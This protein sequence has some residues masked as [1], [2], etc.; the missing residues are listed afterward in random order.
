MSTS[1]SVAP[2]SPR[3]VMP[4]LG[5]TRVQVR[6]DGAM[7]EVEPPADLAVGESLGGEL[8]DLELLRREVVA[9]LR[10]PAPAP[11]AGRAQL[12][13]RLLA[14]GRATPWRSGSAQGRVRRSG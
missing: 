12:T 7:R 2:S 14:P 4:S 1:P 11:F 6:A 10:D 8:R 3:E 13:P 9:G 5:N